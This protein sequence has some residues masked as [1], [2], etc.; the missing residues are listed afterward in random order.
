MSSNAVPILARRV[1][2]ADPQQSGT[3]AAP[4]ISARTETLP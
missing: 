4:W 3:F 2:K 1:L